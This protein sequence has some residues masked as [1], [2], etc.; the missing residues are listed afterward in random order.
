MKPGTKLIMFLFFIVALIVI[1]PIVT[2]WSLNT[3]FPI[4][5]IPLTLETWCAV[6]LL[7][8]FVRGESF[9]SMKGKV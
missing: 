5:E 1:G 8:M 6:V 3:L 4:L 2:I 7:G 9:I